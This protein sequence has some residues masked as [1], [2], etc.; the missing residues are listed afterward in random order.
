MNIRVYYNNNF[1]EF[2]DLDS[3]KSH[4]Q[5]FNIKDLAKFES[6]NFIKN[7]LNGKNTIYSI[8]D[9]KHLIDFFKNNQIYIR[10][11]GGLI[12]KE[13]K[14]LFIKRFGK[15]DL[16]KGK[17]EKNESDEE[18]AIRECEEECSIKQLNII[19]K[20]PSTFHLYELKG[21]IVLKE[22]VWFLMNSNYNGILKPQ[23]EESITEIEW[24]NVSEIK[25]N[26]VLNTYPT[27][28]NLLKDSILN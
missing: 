1:L 11:A 5:S 23:L 9:F 27:I 24:F 21:N 26:V 20:L 13:N 25:T 17:L 6:K 2:I 4:N 14:F 28:N 3:Q 16:P 7:L 15:W 8:A 12:K 18:G 10:A 19:N 22:S